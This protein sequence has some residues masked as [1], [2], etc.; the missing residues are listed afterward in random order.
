MYLIDGVLIINLA[1]E[2]HDIGV[3]DQVLQ[4]LPQKQL[5]VNLLFNLHNELFGAKI[6][7]LMG[8]RRLL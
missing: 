2:E 1:R 8:F 6:C 3:L 7:L 4:F 5:V